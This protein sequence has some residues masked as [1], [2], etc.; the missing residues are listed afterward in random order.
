MSTFTKEEQTNIVK[1]AMELESAIQSQE[2]DLHWLRQ[3]GFRAAPPEPVRQTVEAVAPVVPDYSALPQIHYEFSEF[4]ADDIKERPSLLNKFF[5]THPFK[6]GAITCGISVGITFFLSPFSAKWPALFFFVFLFGFFAV[7]IVPATLVYRIS[8][9][10]AYKQKKEYL[11]MQLAQTP[12]YIQA[13]A[14]AD[15]VAQ[16]RQ[17][18]I[19]ENLRVQQANFDAQYAKEKEEYDT[20]ILPRYHAERSAWTEEHE[21]KIQAVSAQ[22]DADRNELRELYESK[23][24]IPMQ[25]THIDALT[26]IYQMMST[27]DYDIKEAIN[28]YDKEIQRQQEAMRLEE[29]QRANALAEEQNYHLSMQ[30]ELLEEQNEISEHARKQQRNMEFIGAVQRHNTNKHLKNMRK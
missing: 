24:V 30:N 15:N 27:S 8:K 29:Q 25:Y 13:K 22:L 7:M 28:M 9:Q 21:R 19:N 5:S 6:R 14:Q 11:A 18:E 20:V 23:K 17:E 1:R 4:L 12:E 26:Y 16:Q 10:S 3:E 2:E